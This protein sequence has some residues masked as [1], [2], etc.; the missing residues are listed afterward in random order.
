MGRSV[1]V[2][3]DCIEKV[4]AALPRQGYPRQKDLAEALGLA[5]DTVS[6]FLNGKPVDF[7]NFIEISERLG[8]DWK[9]IAD[10]TTP[11]HQNGD[12]DGSGAF[13]IA[14]EEAD[15]FIYIERPPTEEKCYKTLSQPGALLRIK[16][17]GLMGKTS[18]MA[19]L[20]G[21]MGHQGYRTVLLNL[22]YAEATDFSNLENFLKWFCVSVGKNLNLPN[23]LAD[24]WDDEFSSSKV[25]CR[26]Y[27]K[28]Y[29]LPA[30]VSPLV[31]CLD[32]VERIFPHTDIA[33]GFLG[34]LRAWHEE[35]KTND[36]WKKLRLVVVHST[37]VYVPLNI[38]ESP[39]NVGVPIELP[40]FTPEQV[41]DLAHK[42]GFAWDIEQIKALMDMVGGHPYLVG[43][44]FEYLNMNPGATLEKIL[45][46]A[47]TEAGIYGNHLRH[48]WNLVQKD[49][50][51]LDALKQVVTA[52]ENLHLQ[53]IHAYQLNCIGLVHLFGNEVKIACELYSKYFD[54]AF[55]SN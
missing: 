35:A 29:L 6:K 12:G 9:E 52:T 39:F 48:L 26:G 22:H 27:F 21:K 34:L 49:V 13:E 53:R 28:D 11:T 20:L 7:T 24:Y 30:A 40:E 42:Y 46:N 51:L 31:L 3:R 41:K 2:R 33:S 4:K 5:P 50:K 18:L 8:F 25:N 19:N 45:Q 36:I 43:Y 10:T 15:N 16:A 37:E 38:N 44:T 55:H 23:R 17:P 54:D 14:Q 32:E 47:A 1:R